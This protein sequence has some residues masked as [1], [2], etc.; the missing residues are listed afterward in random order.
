MPHLFRS[1]RHPPSIPIEVQERNPGEPD[2]HK[3][4]QVG[5]AT[6]AAPAYFKTIRLEEDDEKSDYIDGMSVSSVLILKIQNDPIVIG[7]RDLELI[8]L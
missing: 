5:R 1:Y 7:A 6:S 3:I 2:N 8:I 4:W